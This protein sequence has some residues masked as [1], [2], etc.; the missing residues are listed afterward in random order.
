MSLI[1]I[2]SGQEPQRAWLREP[3]AGW[4]LTLCSSDF[5]AGPLELSFEL[6]RVVCVNG[7]IGKS[8]LRQVHL[9]RKLPD[10]LGLSESTYRLDS[11][12]QAS[13]ICDITVNLLSVRH[14]KAQIDLMR[15]SS[16]VV[17]DPQEEVQG[18]VRAKRISRIQGEEVERVLMRG[19]D[20]EI[21]T[22]SA[23]Y[24]KLAQAI[25]WVAKGHEDQQND[26]EKLAG[27]LVF[28][29]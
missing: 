15:R 16:S 13:A 24:W 14:I 6:L 7:L 23:T 17:I 2:R 29:A 22:G 3:Q 10:E 26:L 27:T 5:G 18:L 11:E 8:A 1:Y 25:S 20:S 4:L 28:G 19:N 12:T 9:G 21:P